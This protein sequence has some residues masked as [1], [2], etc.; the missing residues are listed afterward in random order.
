MTTLATQ[1]SVFLREHLPRDR[2]ASSHTCVNG[3][4]KMC[5]MAG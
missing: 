3:G 1:L 4:D 2:G 5:Q